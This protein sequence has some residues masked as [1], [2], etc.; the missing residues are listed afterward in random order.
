MTNHIRIGG[1]ISGSG[2]N[3][4]AIMESCRNGKINGTVVVAGADN[5]CS[6]GLSKAG[7]NG[8]PVFVVNY[9]DVIRSYK[10]GEDIAVPHDFHLDEIKSKQ[11]LFDDSI[12]PDFL[13]MF[14]TTRAVCENRLLNYLSEYN[15]DL[16]VL[17]GFMRT[18]TPYFIERFNL[19]PDKPRIMNIHPALLPSFPG[20]DGYGDTFRYGCKIGGCTVHFVD[21]GMDTGTVI[22]QKAYS[23]DPGDTLQDIKKKGLSLEYQLY[24]ECIQLFAE[25]R[26]EIVLNDTGTRR[27]VKIN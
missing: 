23:I 7:D 9:G 5:D 12:D 6:T 26:L 13:E 25:Q 16:L 21:S 1:L 27:V 18:M 24:P 22:G 8:I 10:R 11:T 19:N 17:A 2:T 20:V 3:L 15:L 14:L 4:A